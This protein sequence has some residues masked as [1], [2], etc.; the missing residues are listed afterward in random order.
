ML[1]ARAYTLRQKSRL[2]ISL[3]W[4]AGYT[5][6]ITLIHCGVMTSHMTGNVTHVGEHLAKLNVLDTGFML[7]LVALFLV[8][9]VISGLAIQLSQRKHRRSI[10][11]APIA[12]QAGLLAAL[13]I[14]FSWHAS[15]LHID[16]YQMSSAMLYWT[17]GLACV[18]M[19]LQN[20]TITSISGAAVRTTHLTGVVTDIGTSAVN[21]W[22]WIRD[23]LHRHRHDAARRWKRITI[24]VRRHPEARQIALL[25]TIIASFLFG[26]TVGSW[27]VVHQP[28]IGL[29]PPVLFLMFMVIIDWR[30][31]IADLKLVDHLTDVE[32][33]NLGIDQSHLPADV[34]LWRLSPLV[35]D[36][37]SHTP[38]FAAWL[39]ELPRG[40]RVA[41]LCISHGVHIDAEAA[42]SLKDVARQLVQSDR[43]LI[44]ANVRPEHFQV[45]LDEGLTDVMDAADFCTDIEFAIA[46]A[47]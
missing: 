3:S 15:Q 2:A 46:R 40:V 17:S 10:Y 13:S 31:P 11:I 37:Q 6:A 25:A 43:R 19:G 28:G 12:I 14:L 16:N 4:V 32:L 39:S 5:N 22:F 7:F 41:I 24:A 38:D 26:A 33:K 23:K 47:V 35:K 42:L 44:L 21:L 29:V 20:A 45:F 1:S 34:G 27:V 8:G 18:A 30:E 9:S 36:A